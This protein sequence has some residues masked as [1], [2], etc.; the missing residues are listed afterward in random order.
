VKA[1]S[2]AEGNRLPDPFLLALLD[3]AKDLLASVGVRL[4]VVSIDEERAVLVSEP[5]NGFVDVQKSCELS[6]RILT[7]VAESVRQTQT[8]LV[9]LRCGRRSEWPCTFSLEWNRPDLTSN[10][11]P[12]IPSLE[13]LISGRG[14]GLALGPEAGTGPARA[15]TPSPG[16]ESD[17]RQERTDEAGDLA[18][19]PE[20][21]PLRSRLARRFPP[22]FQ[23]RWWLLLLCFV[24][25]TAG[26]VL[27]SWSKAPMYSAN[28]EIV[29]A[30]GA[31]QQGPG[32][33][34]DA[35][36]LA[37]TDA[38]ILPSDQSLL[39]TVS[40]EIGDSPSS[41]ERD[42]SASVE[43]GTSVI[44][45]SFQ[46]STPSAA[47][48]GANAV[49]QAV[50]SSGEESSTIPN[51]SLAL[52]QLATGASGSGLLQKYGIPLGAL[53]GLLIAF[54]V[55][56]AMERADPRV[57]DVDD[58]AQA[59]GTAASAYPGPI[60]PAELEQLIGR[61]SSGAPAATLVPFSEAEVARVVALRDA[62]VHG[63]DHQSLALDVAGPPGSIDAPLSS[64]QGPTV[65][66]VKEHAKLRD[67]KASAQRLELMGRRPVWAVLARE[68]R[69][70]EVRR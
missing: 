50:T 3:E 60:S 67:V 66:V 46:A 68:G 51:G 59:T 45:V 15:K 58:L 64:G 42:L 11:V 63:A 17:V 7:R 16:L 30:T 36:A 69:L 52:V 20:S 4:S 48:R 44:L 39:R 29:V 2:R 18:K 1:H 57:D 43:A 38:S 47:I 33:A 27:A 37:L 22:W 12:E 24:A 13:M 62:L 49:S 8:E 21:A 9:E 55:V 70:P 6:R 34:N 41:V 26:G 40:R 14:R 10:V 32:N 61:A 19:R 56:M 23:R 25:G 54:V 28:S 31:G 53:L 5:A 35:I 65:L